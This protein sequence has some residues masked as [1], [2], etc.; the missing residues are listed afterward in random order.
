M[1]KGHA[2][3]PPQ[4]PG[5]GFKGSLGRRDGFKGSL[6]RREGFKASLVPN[7]AFRNQEKISRKAPGR[8]PK[9]M[10]LGRQERREGL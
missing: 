1:A 9:D 10:L 7:V 2:A 3:G 5:K 6:G 8:W 4:A